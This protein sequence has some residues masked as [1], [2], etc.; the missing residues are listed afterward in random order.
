MCK[1]DIRVFRVEIVKEWSDLFFRWK[2]KETIVN[3]TRIEH[4]LKGMSANPV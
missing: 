1:L 4:R 3:I 2:D